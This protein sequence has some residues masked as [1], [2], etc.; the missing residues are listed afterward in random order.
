MYGASQSSRPCGHK[1]KTIQKAMQEERKEIKEQGQQRNKSKGRI[2]KKKEKLAYGK[3]YFCEG[4]K[5]VG[6]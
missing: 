3:A 5:Y 4:E 1:P 2:H 6:I